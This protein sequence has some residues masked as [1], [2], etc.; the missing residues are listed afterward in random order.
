MH[1]VCTVN[2]YDILGV[3][4]P[5]A[6]GIQSG[7]G[8]SPRHGFHIGKQCGHKRTHVSAVAKVALYNYVKWVNKT[9]QLQ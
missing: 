8:G 3:Y 6:V 2:I 7:P 5:D 1:A 4:A 9:I